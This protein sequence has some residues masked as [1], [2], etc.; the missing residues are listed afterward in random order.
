MVVPNICNSR[1]DIDEGLECQVDQAEDML[2]P[3]EDVVPDSDVFPLIGE[4]ISPSR[5]DAKKKDMNIV[6][7]TLP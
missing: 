7:F 4:T 6:A 1:V 5:Q 3:S 2:S